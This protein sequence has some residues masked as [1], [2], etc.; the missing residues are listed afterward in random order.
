MITYTTRG[1]QARRVFDAATLAGVPL[2]HRARLRLVPEPAICRRCQG[3]GEVP[4]WSPDGG[5]F[6]DFLGMVPCNCPAAAALIEAQ[7]AEAIAAVG[8]EPEPLFE[9]WMAF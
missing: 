2:R 9:D 5:I 3:A 8:G 4:T 1:G 6:G 7:D